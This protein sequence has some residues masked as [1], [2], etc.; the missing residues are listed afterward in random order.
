VPYVER[1]SD[2]G[3]LRADFF[4]SLLAATVR[5]LSRFPV[6]LALLSG[7]GKK[8]LAGVTGTDFKVGDA[9][10]IDVGRKQELDRIVAHG[11]AIAE[12]DEGDPVIEDLKSRFLPFAIEHMAE[13]KDRLAF[14]F[15]AEIFQSMRGRRR[16]GVFTVR[17]C[18]YQ[19]HE[20]TVL[21]KL[22]RMRR[23]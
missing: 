6:R 18:S 13:D 5:A 10:C 14:A 15:R 20:S 3:T 21:R 22:Y 2:A 12:F 16:T 8:Q 11:S 19:W 23:I 4:N 7:Q 1:L 17:A 9:F